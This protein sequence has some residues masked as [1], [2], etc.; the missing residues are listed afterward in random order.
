MANEPIQLFTQM[1]IDLAAKDAGILA[2]AAAGSAITNETDA[3]SDLDLIVVT[4]AAI[5]PDAARMRAFAQRFPGLIAAFTGEHVGE[6]RLL[7]CLYEDPLLHVDFKFLLPQELENRIENPVILFEREEILTRAYAASTAEWPV[8]DRQWLEDRFWVWIH[9]GALKIG[10]GEFFEAADFLAF[11]RGQVLGPL[12]ALAYGRQPRGVRKLEQFLDAAD[13]AALKATHASL[14]ARALTH[15]TRRVADIYRKL[16]ERIP[17][18]VQ[19]SE[20]AETAAMT[21]LDSLE[22]TR[23]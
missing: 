22:R 8:P 5:A 23:D 1:A 11:L 9:Y 19:K 21:Y 17:V 16:R 20:R 7:I 14:D 13:L 4:S 15:A 2:L 18:A 12:F 10:R 6:R 3:F